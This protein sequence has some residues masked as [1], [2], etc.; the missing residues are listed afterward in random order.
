MPPSFQP[1]S[2][3]LPTMPERAVQR[4]GDDNNTRASE[5][6]E[7]KRLLR[8]SY[9]STNTIV[10][11][12]TERP[13]E[14]VPERASATPSRTAITQWQAPNVMSVD[15]ARIP[16]ELR[17]PGPAAYAR[18]TANDYTVYDGGINT[19]A[20]G[21]LNNGLNPHNAMQIHQ[22]SYF[23][24]PYQRAGP[25]SIRE[26]L[27][28]NSIKGG[29]YTPLQ[30][31]QTPKKPASRQR[32][33]D[34]EDPPYEAGEQDTPPKRRVLTRRGTSVYIVREGDDD[35]SPPPGDFLRLPLMAWLKGPIRNRRSLIHRAW[36]QE[37]MLI[38][39]QTSSLSLANSLARRCSS[40]SPLVCK[41][42]LSS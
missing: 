37:S 20:N 28:E 5:E 36:M 25:A 14:E 41:V 42:R 8:D 21:H 40:S 10:P 16:P 39:S 22:D 26:T 24:Q 1:S 35:G 18:S 7:R 4:P 12:I 31:G 32:W 19:P 15:E 3:V 23:R 17:H 2:G 11:S 33:A 30:S 6:S 9:Q 27:E 38:A 13:S 34:G 29:R